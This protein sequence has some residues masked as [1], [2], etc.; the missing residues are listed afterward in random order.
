MP[1]TSKRFKTIQKWKG[2]LRCRTRERIVEEFLDD[3]SS[4]GSSDSELDNMLHAA[5]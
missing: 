2:I 1:R 4:D 3:S 5:I